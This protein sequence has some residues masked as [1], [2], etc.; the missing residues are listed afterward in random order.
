MISFKM[1]VH[2]NT[3]TPLH[4]LTQKHT[5]CWF[6]WQTDTPLSESYLS[7][8][9]QLKWGLNDEGKRLDGVSE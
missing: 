3:H 5:L 6:T 1:T 4:S 9:D 8:M 2:D 7:K